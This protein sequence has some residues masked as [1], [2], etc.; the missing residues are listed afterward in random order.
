MELKHDDCLIRAVYW[1]G[2]IRALADIAG[3][4]EI[5]QMAD[6][7]CDSLCDAAS[8]TPGLCGRAAQPTGDSVCWQAVETEDEP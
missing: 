6:F 7:A 1:L 8:E 3:Q 5:V 4:G 2:R